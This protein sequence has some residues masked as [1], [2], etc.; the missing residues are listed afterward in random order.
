MAD[1]I[2]RIVVEVYI[3][4]PVP[5]A[6]GAISVGRHPAVDFGQKFHQVSFIHQILFF[7]PLECFQQQSAS[8]PLTGRKPITIIVF[9]KL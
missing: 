7:I 8:P 2:M 6:V 9:Y 5:P 1:D 4:Y 3:I